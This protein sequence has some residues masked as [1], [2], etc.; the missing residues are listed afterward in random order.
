MAFLK[1]NLLH[2]K[3]RGQQQVGLFEIIY[4]AVWVH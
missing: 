2:T 4:F 1:Q 3:K